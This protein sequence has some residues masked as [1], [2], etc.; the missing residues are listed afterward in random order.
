MQRARCLLSKDECVSLVKKHIRSLDDEAYTSNDMEY[1]VKTYSD[2]LTACAPHT[3]RLN[4]D[5]VSASVID[6]FGCEKVVAKKVGAALKEAMSYCQRKGSTATSGVKLSTPVKNVVL[7]F[8]SSNGTLK[9]ALLRSPTICVEDSGAGSSGDQ[10]R[11]MT[12]AEIRAIYGQQPSLSA[13]VVEGVIAL[14]S[15]EEPASKA[16]S[17][18]IKILYPKEI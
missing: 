4:K 11:L 18:Y 9:S 17:V 5:V 1:V 16:I 2:F 14:S 7:Q 3:E 12:E 10:S 8:P 6:V 15:E 13:K